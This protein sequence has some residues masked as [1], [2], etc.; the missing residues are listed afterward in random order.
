MPH[1]AQ[2]HTATFWYGSQEIKFNFWASS[3]KSTPIDVVIFLGTGQVGRMPRWVAQAAPPGVAVVDGLPHWMA[4]PSARD[5]TEFS[6][7]YASAA[8]KAVLNTFDVVSMHV[9]TI[10]QAAPSAI[11]MAQYMPDNVRNIALV[12]PLGFNKGAFGDTEQTRLK[13]L[14]K[15]ALATILQPAQS[16]LRDPRNLVILLQL[17]QTRLSEST[18]GASDKKYAVGLNSDILELTRLVARKREHT[19]KLL[20]IFLGE[21]DKIFPPHEIL[22]TLKKAKLEQI[23][24][25]VLHG[26]THA[27]F[28]IRSNKPALTDI[29]SKVRKS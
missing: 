16:P 4:H 15:R 27:S 17:L 25:E 28:A 2:K 13:E 26:L 24:V 7:E 20:M 22:D 12:A 23:R 29:V 5:L 14:K 9:V 10:S 11:W 8:F 18:W 3:G 1:T 6:R 21:D 19:G